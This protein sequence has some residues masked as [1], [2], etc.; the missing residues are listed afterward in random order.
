M[1]VSLGQRPGRR[2]PGAATADAAGG[3]GRR[4]SAV[5]RTVPAHFPVAGACRSSAARGAKG[6]RC[7]VPVGTEVTS[8]F[9]IVFQPGSQVVPNRK[10]VPDPAARDEDAGLLGRTG[11][12]SRR[13]SSAAGGRPAGRGPGAGVREASSCQVRAPVT[14][15]GGGTRFNDGCRS[16]RTG[17]KCVSH[18]TPIIRTDALGVLAVISVRQSQAQARSLSPGPPSRARRGP[19]FQPQLQSCWEPVP[20][21]VGAPSWDTAAPTVVQE[22]RGPRVGRRLG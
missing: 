1:W 3:L 15:V 6:C 7:C 4:E 13:H 11:A 17:R 5:L 19:R 10:Q 12:F 14:V 21:R 16:Q 20:Q 9:S 18:C 22:Q 2:G 8:L